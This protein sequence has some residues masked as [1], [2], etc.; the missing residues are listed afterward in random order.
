[1]AQFA[2]TRQEMFPKEVHF[3]LF[4]LNQVNPLP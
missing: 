1:M 3:D 2:C 4:L